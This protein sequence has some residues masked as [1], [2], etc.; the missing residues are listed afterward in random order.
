[1]QCGH[2]NLGTYNINFGRP[3]SGSPPNTDPTVKTNILA[4]TPQGRPYQY[5]LSVINGRIDVVPEPASM[6]ALGSGLV[7]LLALRRRRAN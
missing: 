2:C 4:N 5:E 6:I 3:L 1:M 7:G